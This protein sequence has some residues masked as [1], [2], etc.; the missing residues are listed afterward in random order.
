LHLAIR[1]NSVDIVELLLA[2]GADPLTKDGSGNTSLHVAAAGHAHEC[3]R[4]LAENVRKREDLDEV[5]EYGEKT[6][7]RLRSQ[8]PLHMRGNTGHPG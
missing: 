8:R 1:D 5:N 3:L 2:F 6:A 7:M 4:L